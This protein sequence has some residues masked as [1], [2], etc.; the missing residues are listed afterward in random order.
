[1]SDLE[2]RIQVTKALNGNLSDYF[3]ADKE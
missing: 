1:M 3:Y 2:R